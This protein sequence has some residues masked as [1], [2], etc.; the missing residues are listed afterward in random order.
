[1]RYFVMIVIFLQFL[2][3]PVW[4]QSD[5]GK[6]DS[7]AEQ[8]AIHFDLHQ[9]ATTQNCAPVV[10]VTSLTLA[11]F[12]CDGYVP[13][14]DERMFS[15]QL[16]APVTLPTGDATHYLGLG[17]DT[18][19]S[20]VGWTQ[21]SFGTRYYRQ[22]S[23]TFPV[24]VDGI[25]PFAEVDVLSG[26]ITAVRPI[27][28]GAQ[29]GCVDIRQTG[30]D[31]GTLD[32]TASIQGALDRGPCIYIP[33]TRPDSTTAG[34]S[35]ASQLTNPRMI[36][37]FG[38]GALIFTG[39]GEDAFVW[40]SNENRAH[41]YNSAAISS[42]RLIR[43]TQDFT[44]AFAGIACVN[45]FNVHLRLH[46]ENFEKGLFLHADQDGVLYNFFYLA[47]IKDNRVGIYMRT[48]GTGAVNQNTFYGGRINTSSS[49]SSALNMHG[50]QIDHNSASS[51]NGN[52]WYNTNVELFN[53]GAGFTSV[54]HGGGATAGNVFSNNTWEGR[55]ESTDFF[56]SG[57]DMSDNTMVFTRGLPEI[58]NVLA[59]LKGDTD[60]DTL[61]LARNVFTGNRNQPLGRLSMEKFATLRRNH[62]VLEST[63]S[64]MTGP[65]RGIVRITTLAGMDTAVHRPGTLQTDSFLIPNQ[66]DL[67]GFAI[68]LSKEVQDY[69]RVITVFA[70]SPTGDTGRIL[71]EVFNSGGTELKGLGDTNLSFNATNDVYKTGLDGGATSGV[72]IVF[73]PNVATAYVG[74]A[75]GTGTSEFSRVTLWAQADA[76]M[77]LL[78]SAPLA[79]GLDT[80][81]PVSDIV[82]DIPA[83]GDSLPD[84][85]FVRN[86]VAGNAASLGWVWDNANTV[87]LPQALQL[88]GTATDLVATSIPANSCGD[89]G[90]IPVTGAILGDVV[91]ASPDDGSMA[92]GIEQ[93]D[94]SWQ[95]FVGSANV[96]Q[97]RACN[98]T[99][100]AIGLG[101]TQEWRAIVWKY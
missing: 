83:A 89:Y 9:S 94:L 13:D 34:F 25:L 49:T 95:S 15:R 33:L 35:F 99:G 79:P 67:F 71:A 82:P 50:I 4:S 7:T 98:P 20:F 24:P 31:E 6:P 10:P 68:D 40:G 91:M 36:P 27:G 75:N 44:D 41:Q 23:A 64:Q 16:A 28:P 2:A 37:V 32:N 88:T 101:S 48:T 97:I 93:S 86:I 22:Q 100:S 96:V 19:S 53:V 77:S 80:D 39:S 78:L 14:G 56:M 5:H 47:R 17:N 62:M 21:T 30:A 26:I 45:C 92:P 42:L 58:S 43:S 74:V 38:P 70:Y 59:V 52:R 69:K 63:T 81:W 57:R 11:A 85:F 76:N 1:M 54:I 18:F 8:R 84:K 61:S 51:L 55:F 12:A 29:N 90:T 65:A 87:W 72:T 3:A 46:V 60:F 73:G 66:N